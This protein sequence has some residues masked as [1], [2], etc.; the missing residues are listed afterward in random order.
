[1]EMIPKMQRSRGTASRLVVGDAARRKVA[2]EYVIRGSPSGALKPVIDR[3]IQ[4]LPISRKRTAIWRAASSSGNRRYPFD[5]SEQHA[6]TLTPA[7]AM[8][9]SA[10]RIDDGT[11]NAWPPATGKECQRQSGSGFGMAMPVRK[12]SL[13]VT[14]RRAIYAYGRQRTRLPV[15][16]VPSAESASIHYLKSVQDVLSLKPGTLDDTSWLDQASFIWMKS[17]QGWVPVPDGVKPLRG[18][19]RQDF[20]V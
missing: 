7:D 12:D 17:A 1:V 6:C 14:G 4:V 5:R 11:D 16:S 19:L 8:R 10:L 3:Y 20:P 15:C 9:L 2:V 18:K 13:T